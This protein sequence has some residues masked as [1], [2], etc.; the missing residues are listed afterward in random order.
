MGFTGKG[1]LGVRIFIL[2]RLFCLPD[3]IVVIEKKDEMASP[4]GTYQENRNS[5]SVLM[6]KREGNR[7]TGKAG[8]R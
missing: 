6:D 7:Q 5:H 1:G 3:I 4:Y 2:P 8:S